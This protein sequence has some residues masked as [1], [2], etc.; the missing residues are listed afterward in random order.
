MTRPAID[1]PPTTHLRRGEWTVQKVQHS[2]VVT[3]MERNHYAGGAGNTSVF[4]HG[5]RKAIGLD[6]F[7]QQRYHW[8]LFGAAIWLPPMRPAAGYVGR[9][10]EVDPDRVLALSRLAVAEGVPTNGASFLLG[11]SIRAI[12]ASGR[13]DA[14]VTWADDR[15]GHTGA[16]YRA[17]NWTYDGR[18]RTRRLWMDPHG[19]L[20]SDRTG[21]HFERGT[22]TVEECL[23]LGWTR[24]EPSYKHRFVMDLR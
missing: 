8:T 18:T 23:A 1:H 4:A 3:F 11:G 17:T 24:T 19:Q 16:I 22:M 10:L 2:D 20:R 7:G 21:R 5:L 12:R 9:L 6:L 13:W 15:L 14:L